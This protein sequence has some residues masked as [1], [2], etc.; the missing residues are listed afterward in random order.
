MKVDMDLS[1]PS[2]KMW[3]FHMKYHNLPVEYAMEIA[4]TARALMNLVKTTGGG[5]AQGDRTYE[6]KFS[7][8]ADEA[9]PKAI[10]PDVSELFKGSA[11]AKNLLYSQA[12]EIQDAGVT[13]LQKLQQSA[14]MEIQSGQRK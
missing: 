10:P 9:T 14:H 6:V 13:L 12:V 1:G 5:A 8:D 3:E 4:S 7:Y 11:H 2:G